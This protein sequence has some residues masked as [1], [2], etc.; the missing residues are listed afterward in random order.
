MKYKNIEEATV[1]LLAQEI[2]KV[3]H[4]PITQSEYDYMTNNLKKIN[5]IISL[6][7]NDL[8]FAK[9][10][11]DIPVIDRLDFLEDKI[12]DYAKS[13]TIGEAIAL[14]KLMEVLYVT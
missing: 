11:F 1:E 6:K 2:S 3:E 10:L 12:Y 9:M 5:K 14:N 7:K 13:R 8:E 4:I